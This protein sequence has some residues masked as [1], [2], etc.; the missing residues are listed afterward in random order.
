L[1]AKV[2]Q[3]LANL[4]EFSGGSKEEYMSCMNEFVS[5][6]MKHMKEFLDKVADPNRT[7]TITSNGTK[8]KKQ[9]TP[10]ENIFLDK[11]LASIYRHL[12]K[13]QKEMREAAQTE[14]QIKVMHQLDEILDKLQKAEEIQKQAMK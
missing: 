4:I 12:K 1:I 3:N 2:L 13:N 14:D 5:I 6:N 10:V 8:V 11:E 7:F 9:P